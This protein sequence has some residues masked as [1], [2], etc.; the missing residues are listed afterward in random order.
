MIAERLGLL[1]RCGLVLFCALLLQ[2]AV[3][4]DLRAFDAVGDLILLMA[5][6]AGSSGGPDRGATIGFAAGLS[7]DLLLRTPFGLSAL[8]CVL[9]GYAAG[10]AVGAAR[11]PQWWFHVVAAVGISIVA[12]VFSMVVARI[13]GMAFAFNDVVRSAIVV[14]VWN[15]LLVLPARRL[16]RWAYGEVDSDRYRVLL[17]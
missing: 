9:A 13:L 3:V 17:P 6:A 15:G 14:A 12:V 16:W 1:G 11:E 7:Y 2:V 5:I 4:S 10:W 8:T